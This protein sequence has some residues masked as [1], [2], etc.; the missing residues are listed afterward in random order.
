MATIT[1]KKRAESSNL[2]NGFGIEKA[3]WIVLRDGVKIGY[4]IGGRNA[5]G[6][7]FYSTCSLRNVVAPTR[8]EL[9]GRV[10]KLSYKED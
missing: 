1:I 9:V 4:A 7:E 8:K 2:G 5:R 6:W 3:Q 10:A